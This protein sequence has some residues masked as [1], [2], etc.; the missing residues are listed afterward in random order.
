MNLLSV[1]DSV[2]IIKPVQSLGEHTF[3]CVHPQFFKIFELLFNLL[4]TIT[5]FGPDNLWW[6]DTNVVDVVA[7]LARSEVFM[8][9]AFVIFNLGE[10]SLNL[11]FSDCE[12]WPTYCCC[13]FCIV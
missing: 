1:S 2:I 5:L 10:V 11:I 13:I 4:A 12:V 3:E 9:G 7:T 6:L 8:E